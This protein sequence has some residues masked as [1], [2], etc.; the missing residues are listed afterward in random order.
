[1]VRTQGVSLTLMSNNTAYP[2]QDLPSAHNT[3][4]AAVTR[5]LRDNQLESAHLRLKLLPSFVRHR[6]TA[7]WIRL[8][9]GC[10]KDFIVHD[11]ILL[12]AEFNDRS[13]AAIIG[14]KLPYLR[15][16]SDAA[17]EGTR[18][19]GGQ[20]GYATEK[21]QRTERV[22]RGS[23][24]KGGLP[25]GVLREMEGEG[26]KEVRLGFLIRGKGYDPM[27]AAARL[28]VKPI[29]EVEKSG[30]DAGPICGAMK[31]ALGKGAAAVQDGDKHQR[32]IPKAATAPPSDGPAEVAQQVMRATTIDAVRHCQP[33]LK[34]TNTAD[35]AGQDM[36]SVITLDGN[37][38]DGLLSRQTTHS[39]TIKHEPG[40]NYPD[41]TDDLQHETASSAA[42]EGGKPRWQLGRS[43]S[44]DTTV[45]TWSIKPADDDANWE[46]ASSSEEDNIA[47]KPKALVPFN[48]TLAVAKHETSVVPKQVNERAFP[49]L[50]PCFAGSYDGRVALSRLSPGLA[51]YSPANVREIATEIPESAFPTTDA[52]TPQFPQHL[53]QHLKPS[54]TS[55]AHLPESAVQISTPTTLLSKKPVEAAESKAATKELISTADTNKLKRKAAVV[56][57][58]DEE[59][60]DLKYEMAEIA[61]KKREMEVGKRLRELAK[62]KRMVGVQ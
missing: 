3:A 62:R 56:D 9:V 21:W 51:G 34:Q 18:I 13:P 37:T 8:V 19:D 60:E 12:R 4:R 53:R 31:P 33:S 26:G 50:S 44:P 28:A 10:K 35:G 25:Q 6:C 55:L 41:E 7:L 38:Q 40:T 14:I 39:V 61:L 58:D 47:I 45:F 2:E 59:E 22:K 54:T 46:T 29:V 15:L 30:V 49:K 52:N 24:P 5:R 57:E 16:L 43:R 32:L 11:E 36:K 27:A 1:M 42:P 20:R 48:N 23:R 17:K